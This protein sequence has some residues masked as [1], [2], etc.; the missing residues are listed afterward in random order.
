MRFFLAEA[1]RYFR[2]HL[3]VLRNFMPRDVHYP[4]VILQRMVCSVID[5]RSYAGILY[6]RHP[7]RGQ[8][9]FLQYATAVFGEDLM[10]GRLAP[11]EGHFFKRHETRHDFPAVYHFWDRLFQLEAIFRGPV[12]VEFTGV[13]GTFTI[14]QVNAAELSGSGMLTAVMD[15]HRAGRIDAD[16]VRELIRPYHVRQIESD[17][18]DPRSIDTLEPFARG[19]AVLPRSAVTGR[20]SFSVAGGDAAARARSATRR[21]SSWRR[22]A[23]RRRTPSTCRRCGAS[24]ASARPPSTSSRRPRTSASRPCSISRRRACASTRRGGG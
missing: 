24:A 9:V 20:L 22:T 23:S 3:G 14:L 15:L 1:Y 13:H 5:D 12:M 6:S 16:R 10:T 19:V 4:A 7:R 18:I 11:R 21:T 17:A 8:G 2:N